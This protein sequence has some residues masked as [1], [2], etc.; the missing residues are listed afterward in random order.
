LINAQTEFAISACRY[1]S[2]V[3]PF[4]RL[5]HSISARRFIIPIVLIAPLYNAPRKEAE[6]KTTI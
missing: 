6:I 3:V 2:V 4:F 5:K 1:I